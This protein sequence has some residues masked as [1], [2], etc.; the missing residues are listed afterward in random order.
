M[1][2]YF[3]WQHGIDAEVAGDENTLGLWLDIYARYSLNVKVNSYLFIHLFTFISASGL[4]TDVPR[5]ML[6]DCVQEK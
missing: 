6:S 4:I 2:D 1:F 3:C 5:V